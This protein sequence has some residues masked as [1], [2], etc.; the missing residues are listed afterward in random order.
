M[1]LFLTKLEILQFQLVIEFIL[2]IVMLLGLKVNM[3][4]LVT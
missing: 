4:V 2:V 3:V 1:D